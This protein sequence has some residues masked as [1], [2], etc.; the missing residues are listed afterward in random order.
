MPEFVLETFIYASPEKCF[1]LMRD[2]RLHTETTAP[3]NEK[4]V[5]GVTDG[6]LGFGQTVTFEGT[7]L[8]FR[9]R[10]TVKVVEF[11]R[12]YLFV[13]E[14]TEGNFKTFRHV[15]EFSRQDGGTQMRDTVTWTSPF[16]FLGRLADRFLI[17]PHLRNLVAKRN[18]MLKQIAEEGSSVV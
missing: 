5:D 18:A 3:T 13:D 16:G 10:L 1:D 4:A 15:H 7:H 2:V 17:E 8:G 9:Q 12:P 6:M 11:E 14:M